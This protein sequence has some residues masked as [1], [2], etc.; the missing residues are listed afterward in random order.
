[1]K[2]FYL[3]LIFLTSSGSGTTT[4]PLPYTTEAACRASG[5]SFAKARPYRTDFV[6]VP[7]YID[8]TAGRVLIDDPQKDE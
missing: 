2:I 5:D 6:C 8:M 3:V 7:A 1:M 4:I